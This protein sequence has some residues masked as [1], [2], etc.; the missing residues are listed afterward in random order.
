MANYRRGIGDRFYALPGRVRFVAYV[1]LLTSF[2][3]L[4]RVTDE[5]I[6]KDRHHTTRYWLLIVALSLAFWTLVAF[7][8][9]GVLKYIR[10]RK[11]RKEIH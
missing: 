5:V 6:V 4:R 3:V 2:S 1:L 11:S 10:Y 9:L 7:L 8:F